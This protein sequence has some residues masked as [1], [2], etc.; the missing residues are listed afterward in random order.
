[1]RRLG[2]F[3]AVLLSVSGFTK[4]VTIAVS[5]YPVANI[6][7]QVAGP[8]AAVETV[9]PPF[10]NPH[11]FS[12]TPSTAVKLQSAALFFGVTPE[13]DGWIRKFLPEETKVVFL[14][15]KNQPN[16]HIWLYPEGGKRIAKA[17][18]EILS[19]TYPEKAALFQ[20]NLK[21]FL[22][23]MDETGRK[24]ARV[25]APVRGAA[26]IQYH[27]AWNSFAAAYGLKIL[28]TISNGHGKE[29]SPRE[30]MNLIQKAR[31][32]H[33][34]VVVMGLH[35]SSRT[36][37][38]LIREIHGREL[39]LDALGNPEDP[40]RNCYQKLLFYNAQKLAEALHD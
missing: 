23:S 29:V 13:F 8:A 36:A 21:R 4:P 31:A 12:P 26:F 25:L 35:K 16:E 17:V 18:A 34:K 39:R 14:K 38:T 20:Q 5:V 30:L 24:L 33:V 1:M 40:G 10:A 11:H 19:K 15:G 9:I 6:V 28:A 32:A 7:K 22:N 3:F 37:Q 27:P 2:L